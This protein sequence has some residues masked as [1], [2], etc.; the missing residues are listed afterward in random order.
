L[1]FA[2]VV[3]QQGRVLTQPTFFYPFAFP[4][5]AWFAWRH[6]LPVDRYDLLG[7]EQPRPQFALDFDG[8]AAR[9]LFSGWGARGGDDFGPL[10]W[11]DSDRAEL[12]VPFDPA[13]RD[14]VTLEVVAR[15][16]LVEPLVPVLVDVIVNGARVAG[17]SPTATTASTTT[18]DIDAGAFTS[19]FNRIALVKRSGTP[20]VAIYRLAIFIG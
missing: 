18:L 4:A 19:G 2:Q 20:P 9:F 17:F 6:G 13:G 14:R 12:I 7:P 16:R 11:M 10:Y 5:N 8:R 15:A 3:R 1:S